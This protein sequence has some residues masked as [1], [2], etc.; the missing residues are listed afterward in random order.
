MIQRL[1]SRG[2]SVTD[3]FG[4]M[5]NAPTASTAVRI[6]TPDAQPSQS[7][8]TEAYPLQSIAHYLSTNAL[9]LTMT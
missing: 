9:A 5:G 4:D 3:L 1:F 2:L 7:Q 6:F 8:S